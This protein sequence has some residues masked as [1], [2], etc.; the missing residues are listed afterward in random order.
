MYLLSHILIN[1]YQNKINTPY[2]NNSCRT[3]DKFNSTYV[4]ARV[5]TCHCIGYRHELI[6]HVGAIYGNRYDLD[7]FFFCLENTWM[8]LSKSR[9]S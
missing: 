8:F 3:F 5:R 6:L 7:G 1:I 4:S 2:A 9:G